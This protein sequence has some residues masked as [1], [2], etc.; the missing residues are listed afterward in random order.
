MIQ[1]GGMRG[2]DEMTRIEAIGSPRIAEIAR[3]TMRGR[4]NRGM[5]PAMTSDIDAVAGNSDLTALEGSYHAA[6]TRPIR[7][8]TPRM[9]KANGALKRAYVLGP[10]S[11]SQIKRRRFAKRAPWRNASGP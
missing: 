3:A 1:G 6:A 11:R 7:R 8:T 2:K 9:R 5:P 4:D 10:A